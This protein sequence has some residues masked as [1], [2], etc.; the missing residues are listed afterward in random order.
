MTRK[1]EIKIGKA[2]GRRMLTW[3]GKKALTRAIACP[4][5]C[6]GRGQ[7]RDGEADDAGQ[8]RAAK[9]LAPG[10]VS[11]IYSGRRKKQDL[12]PLGV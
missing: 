5:L 4:P 1:D 3:V 8:G 7:H 6:Q 11:Y 12:I 9:S 10:L 2:K